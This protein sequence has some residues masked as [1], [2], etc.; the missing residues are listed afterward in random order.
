MSH[1]YFDT[2]PKKEN[3]DKKVENAKEK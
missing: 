2:N 1:Y 3:P